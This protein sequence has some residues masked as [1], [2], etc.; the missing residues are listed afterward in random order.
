MQWNPEQWWKGED[1]I[2]IGGGSSLRG[3]DWER[4][5]DHRVIGI[6]DAYQLGEEICDAVVFGDLKWYTARQQYL[7]HFKNP[8]FSNQPSLHVGSPIWLRTMR[9]EKNGLSHGGLYWGNN[10][11]C[12]AVNLALLLGARRVMLLGF[13]MK[14][15][16]DKKL[17]W[18]PSEARVTEQTFMRFEKGFRIIAKELNE[19]FPDREII[20]LGPDSD[21]DLFPFRD[22]DTYLGDANETHNNTIGAGACSVGGM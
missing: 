8:V 7:Q 15:G 21:L 17:N 6:N 3:F 22:L 19:K 2:L 11:G 13:D 12:V 5:R 18:H 20:N 14:V 10:T 16:S 1:I 4:L 9:R